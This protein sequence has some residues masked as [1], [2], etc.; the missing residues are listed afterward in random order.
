MPAPLTRTL[1]LLIAASAELST[2]GRGTVG[3]HGQCVTVKQASTSV[4]ATSG[5]AALA[6]AAPGHTTTVLGAAGAVGTSL[7]TNGE[8]HFGS[9]IGAVGAVGM[10]TTS[11][12]EG[13]LVPGT[14]SLL[15]VGI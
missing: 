15:G 13:T 5:G 11:A 9:G 8:S 4:T 7:S 6:G 14:L 12:A 2:A 1:A 10:C 3:A